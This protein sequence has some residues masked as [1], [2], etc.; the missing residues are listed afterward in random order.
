MKDLAII[1]AGGFGKEVKTLVDHINQQEPTWNLLGFFDD[2]PIKE[3]HGLPVLGTIA[4]LLN[5]HLEL[6]LVISIGN[7]KT[8]YEI[9]KRLVGVRCEFATLIHP[10]VIIG[11]PETVT[12]GAGSIVTAGVILTADI[13]VKQHVIINLNATVGHDTAVCE[14]SSIMPGVNLAG[15][16]TLNKGAFVGAGANILGG[17]KL[18]EFCTVGAGAVVTRDIPDYTIAVGV[19]ARVLKN[20]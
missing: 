9:A 20:T 6:E 15:N 11:D 1:G 16:V 4:D 12:I 10:S 18:G 17:V 3:V 8:R 13:T 7:S 5:Q 2:R 19:P 14:Y